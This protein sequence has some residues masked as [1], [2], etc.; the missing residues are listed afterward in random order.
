MNSNFIVQF[1]VELPLPDSITPA[2]GTSTEIIRS[3]EICNISDSCVKLVNVKTALV[4]HPPISV[5][6]ENETETDFY[7]TD[8]S[9]D[10]VD[11]D[12]DYDQDE[13]DEGSDTDNGEEEISASSFADNEDEN[14]FAAGENDAPKQNDE[15]EKIFLFPRF[16]TSDILSTFSVG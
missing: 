5:A 7:H 15:V 4:R 10:E 11:D 14:T 3:S 13:E 8:E 12:A 16:L 2:P 9:T 1:Q 6:L